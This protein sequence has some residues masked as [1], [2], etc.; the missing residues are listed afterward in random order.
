MVELT[1]FSLGNEA[2]KLTG[3]RPHKTDESI[4]RMD[5]DLVQHTNHILIPY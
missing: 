4:V 5:M 1:K 2:P 3:M